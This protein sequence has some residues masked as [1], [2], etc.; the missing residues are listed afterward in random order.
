MQE[1]QKQ[2]IHS[3]C[4][5]SQQTLSGK[6]NLSQSFSVAG[7]GYFDGAAERHKTTGI[8]TD[9][10][11]IYDNVNTVDF[12]G[13][14]FNEYDGNDDVNDNNVNDGGNDDGIYVKDSDDSQ[15]R[16]DTFGWNRH[17]CVK[18]WSNITVFA[19]WF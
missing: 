12:N 16:D 8:Q 6:V 13:N 5:K 7:C 15:D 1:F 19:S 2:W 14:E 4:G 10:D 11:D 18:N 3:F 9:N 17:E